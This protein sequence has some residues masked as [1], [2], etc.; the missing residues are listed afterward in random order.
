MDKMERDYDYELEKVDDDKLVLSKKIKKWEEWREKWHYYQQQESNILEEITY[1]SRGTVSQR[2]SEVQMD[3]FDFEIQQNNHLFGSIE[4]GFLEEKR[5]IN[6]Q[7]AL[8]IEER[9][10]KRKEVEN[11]KD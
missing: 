4:E 9:S 11:A 6:K 8:L 1:Y 2:Q 3:Y 5:S 7:E 10:V